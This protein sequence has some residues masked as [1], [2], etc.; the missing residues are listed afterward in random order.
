MS[1]K[2]IEMIVIREDTIFILAD[3]IPPPTQ[4]INWD[5]VFVDVAQSKGQKELNDLYKRVVDLEDNFSMMQ[6]AKDLN[7]MKE[8]LR[9]KK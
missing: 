4:K 7:Q 2:S 5:S 9:Q 1:G 3:T 8:L 6:G